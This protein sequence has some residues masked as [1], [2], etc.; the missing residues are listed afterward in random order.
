MIEQKDIEEAFARIRGHIHHTPVFTSSYFNNLLDAEIFFK[1]ENLQKTGS[2]KPRGAT[3]AVL[4][5]SGE[6]AAKGVAT[7][8]SGNHGQAL[9][10]AARQRGIPAYVVMPENA[11]RVKV[12][13]VKDYGT[14]VIFCKAT[15][16]AREESL[17]EILQKTGASFIPP[18]NFEDTIEGQA[19]CG[20]EIFSDIKN[21]DYLLVPVGG[22]GLLAGCALS[23]HFYAPATKVVGCEP[24]AADD[25]QRS[26]RAG[27][28]LPGHDPDTLADGL[29]TSLGE[30]PFRYIQKY[31]HDIIT[32]SEEKIT[33]AMRLVWERMKLVVEASA[34]VPL[35]CM[36]EQKN[37]FRGK[38]VAVILSGGN[39]DLEKLAF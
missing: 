9:A 8:S 25:A 4:K 36:M 1:A 24:K 39:T 13:A 26:F 3:N 30:V 10:W 31:A 18:F 23:G 37:S 33:E 27:K 11:P 17:E 32:C 38:R 20:T 15:Q 21:L 34:A 22:G 14:E 19:S 6:A 2:F 12:N 7:H 29:R 28:I 35:A 5:L 16:R